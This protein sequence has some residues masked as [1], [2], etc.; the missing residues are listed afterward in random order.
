MTDPQHPEGEPLPRE[1]EPASASEPPTLTAERVEDPPPPPP[2]P[3]RRQRSAAPFVFLL[4]AVVIGV[5]AFFLYKYQLPH[6]QQGSQPDQ[7]VAA[8]Q[9]QVQ[10]LTGQVHALQSRPAG[11]PQKLDALASQ[12]AALQKAPPQA[13]AAPDLGPVEHRLDALEKQVSQLQAAP[14]AQSGASPAPAVDLTPIQNR[15]GALQKQVDALQAAAKQPPPGMAELRDH[16]SSLA[17]AMAP[18]QGQLFKLANTQQGQAETQQR[19]AAEQQRLSDDVQKLGAE[20]QRLSTDVQKLGAEQP[21]LEAAQQKLESEQQT[22]SGQLAKSSQSAAALKSLSDRVDQQQTALASLKSSV[23]Q[24]A[25]DAKHAA[26]VA[27]VEAALAALDAGHAVGTLQN[28]PA[29]V[30]RFAKTPPP[31]LTELRAQFP[32]VAKHILA[33]SEPTAGKHFLDRLWT[34]AQDLVTVRQGSHVLVGDPAAGLVA[35]AQQ[36]LDHN[37]LSGAVAA[38][39]NLKGQAAQAAS[40]WLQSAHDLLAARSALLGMAGAA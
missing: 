34:N 7:Q 40:D 8:L 37:D 5:A 23:Q 4:G 13:S 20:Q 11:D 17:T 15:I 16:L 14:K 21:K 31:T 6:G 12:V 1:P 22:L 2:P 18:L 29:S 9:T 38:L 35:E 19:Y 10:A 24:V 36:D 3:R 26:H 39:S 32:A 33:A 28:A 30:S 25:A 27:Q